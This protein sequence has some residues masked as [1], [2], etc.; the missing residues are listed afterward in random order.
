M[1]VLGGHSMADASPLI[2]IRGLKVHRGGAI[3]LDGINL[4]IHQGDFVGVVGPNGSGKSTLLLTIIGELQP[5]EGTV[6]VFGKSPRL[7]ATSG[8]LAWVSQAASN[9]SQNLRITVR[10]LVGL[11]TLTVANMIRPNRTE[12]KKR[13]NDAIRMV[14]LEDLADRDIRHMSGGQRQ[15]AVVA[16]GLA[17]NAEILIL[18]EPLVGVD[19]ESRKDFLRFLEN[20]CRNEGKTLLMVTHDHTA[21]SR[22]THCAVCID[23]NVHVDEEIK[24]SLNPIILSSIGNE[25][26]LKESFSLEINLQSK[27]EE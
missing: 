24:K 23:G 6:S 19:R 13:V 18:D 2:S 20:L 5:T 22:C 1:G 15:R 17:S 4:D 7:M 11:G 26:D 25:I 14:G 8:R 16:R 3:V 12:R 10:E 21:I 27:E 9:L